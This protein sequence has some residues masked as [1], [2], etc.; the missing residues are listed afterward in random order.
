MSNSVL[1][2]GSRYGV[3]LPDIYF[4]K[5][6][7]AN[8]AAELVNVYKK[9][10]K[11]IHHTSVFGVDEFIKNNSVRDKIIYSQPDRLI[12]RNGNINLKNYSFKNEVQVSKISSINDLKIQISNLDLSIIGFIFSELKYSEKKKIN[13]FFKC[14]RKRFFQGFSSG[15]FASLLASYEN[16]NSE[17]VISGIGLE[18]GGG[19]F[20]TNKDHEGFFSKNDII[21]KENKF[22]NTNR[23]RVEAHLFKNLK[24]E[25]KERMSSPSK[26]FCTS[27]KIRYLECSLIS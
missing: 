16:P 14:L 1:V 9:K 26:D 19:H 22:R 6:Y 7:S 15:L 18:H 12:I 4:K 3:K 17:I 21:K 20:Y 8:G 23:K 10:Y 27:G 25:I 11:E 24:N 2:L 13:Y 5:I